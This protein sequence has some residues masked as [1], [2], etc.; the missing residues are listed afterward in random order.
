[1]QSIDTYNKFNAW[2][3]EQYREWLDSCDHCGGCAAR[4]PINPHNNVELP[5]HEWQSPNNKCPSF[6]YYKF[7]SHTGY[8]RVQLASSRF[9][10]N[11]PITDDL[12]NI[13]YT[14]ASC[15]ICNEI[16]PTHGPMNVILALREEIVYQG[17]NV[18]SPLDGM[19]ANMEHAHNLFGLECRRR[20]V[21]ELPKTGK[22][23]Y[24][25]GC[26]TSYLL[27]KL[28]SAGIAILKASGLE[29]AH[30]GEDE[31]CCGEVAK[32]A[33][34][35][36]LFRRMAEENV[37]AMEKAGAKRVIVN[38]AHCYKTWRIDYPN[39]VGRELP[40]EV[41]HITDVIAELIKTGKIKFQ[42]EQNETVT[43]HDPCF[44]RED[45]KENMV[46]R[47]ILGAI[48]GVKL[49]EM[50]RWGRWSYCCGAGGK[51]A[52]NCYP[53][54]AASV[55]SERI[56]E[57]KDAAGKVITACPVCYNQLR[58][59]AK[60]EEVEIEVDDITTVVAKAM[61]LEI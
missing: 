35:L 27:P 61:G 47:E 15:G 2:N 8:G 26:Y 14:C 55:G 41:A 54:F 33:G 19:F 53:D 49:A 17:C 43:F 32:Q 5:P 28:G 24:F 44:L 40:F 22:D 50:E 46:P 1:M 16:C 59:S 12:V 20:P 60:N 23:V 48:P 25:T 31:H 57:A 10:D 52:E 38:C 37:A 21:P 34:N 7:R 13:A 29:P 11:T 3:L 39:A 4:G 6:E 56:R 58:F 45:H 30:L 36:P 42:R 51:I 9:R 18:P